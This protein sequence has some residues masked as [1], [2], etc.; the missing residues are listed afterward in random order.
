MLHERPTT[1]L[2]SKL[3]WEPVNGQTYLEYGVD[4][5]TRDQE[6]RTALHH[7]AGGDEFEREY[8]HDLAKCLIESGA[9]VAAVDT[10]GHTHWTLL[11]SL[12]MKQLPTSFE[13]SIA[14]TDNNG[15]RQFN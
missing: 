6:Q 13:L 11:S 8:L 14:M 9:N 4:V 7:I 1:V 5:N 2:L 15:R 10:F 12:A 3:R